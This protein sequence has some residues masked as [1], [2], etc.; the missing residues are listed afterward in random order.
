MAGLLT[1]D[2]GGTTKVAGRSNMTG[3]PPPLRGGASIPK[4]HSVLYIPIGQ[5]DQRFLMDFWDLAA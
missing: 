2:E 3:R 5:T 1:L 4:Q